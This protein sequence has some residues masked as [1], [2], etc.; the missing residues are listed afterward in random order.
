MFEGWNEGYYAMT[1]SPEDIDSCKQYI[2][3]QESHHLNNS[4]ID[5]V[6]QIATKNGLDWFEEDWK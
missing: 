1:L 4:L 6:H 3:N 5:E 2:I